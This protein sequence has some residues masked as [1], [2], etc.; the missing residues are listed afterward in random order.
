MITTHFSLIAQ[1]FCEKTPTSLIMKDERFTQGLALRLIHHPFEG[2]R[3]SYVLARLRRNLI[4]SLFVHGY[5]SDS[6]WEKTVNTNQW[7]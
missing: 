4:F 5:E 6:R 1:P 3:R 7:R 2:A